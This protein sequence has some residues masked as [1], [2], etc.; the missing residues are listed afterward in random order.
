MK[1]KYKMF[2]RGQ[3]S[4]IGKFKNGDFMLVQINHY[5][6]KILHKIP[7]KTEDFIITKISDL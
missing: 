1:R 7:I 2:Y 6:L 4:W 5:R 3:G